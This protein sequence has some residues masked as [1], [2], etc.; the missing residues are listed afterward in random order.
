M[1][2]LSKSANPPPL[3]KARFHSQF[4]LIWDCAAPEQSNPTSFYLQLR[5]PT[6]SLAQALEII[7]LKDKQD[8]LPD[9]TEN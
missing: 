7:L 9:P 1:F 6:T 2:L 3:L 8:Q 5:V 4:K